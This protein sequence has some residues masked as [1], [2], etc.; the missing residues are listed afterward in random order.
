MRLPLLFLLGLFALPLRAEPGS[1][2][3]G[4]LLDSRLARLTGAEESLCVHHG[5]VVLAV[6]TASE[7]GFTPQYEGLEALYQ[8]YREQGLVV[9]G[10]PSDQFGGQEYADDAEIARFCKI[11]FGVSFPMYTR[12]A[13]IGDNAIPLYQGL[14]AATGEAPR[15]NFH[16][17]LIGRDGRALGAWDSRVTPEAPALRSA[18]EAALAAP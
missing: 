16:K 2:C 11:N 14:K 9:I 3:A 1:D 5:K 7:C 17:F 12:S 13:V 6:N 4:S 15:W 8:R 10:I 18:I